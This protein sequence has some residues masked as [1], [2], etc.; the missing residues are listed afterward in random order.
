MKKY[1]IK[2][3][4]IIT[5]SVVIKADSIEEARDRINTGHYGKQEEYSKSS[6]RILSAWLCKDEERSAF[7][8]IEQQLSDKG[9][10]EQDRKDIDREL[11]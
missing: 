8:D 7:K 2:I 6:P 9:L 3:E 10:M 1:F 4:E 5:S 11:I